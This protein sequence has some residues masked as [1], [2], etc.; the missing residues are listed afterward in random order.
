[1][2]PDVPAP[3][4]GGC[5]EVTGWTD[6]RCVIW[7]ADSAVGVAVSRAVAGR[8]SSVLLVQDHSGASGEI[9]DAL[10]DL[11]RHLYLHQHDPDAIARVAR[12]VND[13]WGRLDA[14]IDCTSSMELGPPEED[15]P[16]SLAA[17]LA[18][19]VI[20]PWRHTEA[21]TGALTAGNCPAIVYLGSIDGL[22]GNP[23]VPAYSAGKAGV[24]SLTRTMAARLGPIGIRVNCVAAAGVLQTPKSHG[25]PR[26]V[27]GDMDAAT[28]LTPL[29][30]MPTGD[31]IANVAVFL[32]SAEASAVTGAVVPVDGGRTAA[33]PGTW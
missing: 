28:R 10:E 25:A 27:L 29:G 33:T 11:P 17:V 16:E 15:T 1:M 4:Q 31:E 14:L 23:Q 32:A 20:S 22:R 19:N 7:G 3:R 13:H 12:W 21:L 24:A 6:R 26:R 18:A 2:F 9:A 8:T 5:I 30:R